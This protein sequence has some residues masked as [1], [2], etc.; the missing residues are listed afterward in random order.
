MGEIKDVLVAI[1]GA[2]GAIYADRLLRTLSG[3]V[4]RIGLVISPEAAEIAAAGVGLGRGLR[5][6][7]DQRASRRR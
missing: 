5:H 4:P 2:S 7:P 3:L 6:A 1:T